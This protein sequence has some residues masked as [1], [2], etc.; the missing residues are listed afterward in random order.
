M[1]GDATPA[2]P[3]P[4]PCP[5]L[6]LPLPC[7]NSPCLVSLGRAARRLLEQGCGRDTC[8]IALGGGVVGDVV[9]FVASTF[10]R[11]VPVVQVPTSLLAM[12]DASIGGKTG[13]DTVHGKNLVGA[14]HQ[15]ARVYIDLAFLASLPRRHLCNGLAE[16]IKVRFHG[17]APGPPLPLPG[18][19]TVSGPPLP[20]PLQ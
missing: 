1:T 18:S 8:L 10:M 19:C 13:V 7:L 3:L 12:V 11:G 4:L 2:L 6:A 5:C 20:A 9:G 14:F 16:V 17:P 15:P